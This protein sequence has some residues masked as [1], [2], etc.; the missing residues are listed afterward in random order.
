MKLAWSEKEIRGMMGHFPPQKIS[1]VFSLNK[2]SEPFLREVWDYFTLNGHYWMRNYRFS[3][4]FLRE[5]KDRMH[6]EF[7][8]EIIVVSDVYENDEKEKMVKEFNLPFYYEPYENEW[9]EII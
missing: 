9:Y 5:M 3:L 1:N 8:H 4:N 7:W 2:F 6:K